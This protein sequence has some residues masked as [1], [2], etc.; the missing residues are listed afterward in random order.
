MR[1]IQVVV[2]KIAPNCSIAADTITVLWQFALHS[3]TLVADTI[4]VL[5]QFALHSFTLHVL[6]EVFLFCFVLFH[7][8][9]AALH[10]SCTCSFHRCFHIHIGYLRDVLK[11]HV[12]L[13]TPATPL[14]SES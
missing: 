8:R 1:H 4:T 3:F 2:A 5:W 13:H 11:K 14:T 12:D 7:T 6:F 10:V 9:L